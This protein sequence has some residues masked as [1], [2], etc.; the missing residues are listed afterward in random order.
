MDKDTFYAHPWNV[1]KLRLLKQI[2]QALCW[3][4]VARYN[5]VY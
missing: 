4:E 3:N 1:W 5:W 2:A